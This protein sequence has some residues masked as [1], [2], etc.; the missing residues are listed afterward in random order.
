MGNAISTVRFRGDVEAERRLRED[1]SLRGSLGSACWKSTSRDAR[2]RLLAGAVRVQP[3]L[4]PEAWRA[5][6]RVRE[7]SGDGTRIELY[8]HASPDINAAVTCG[9]DRLLVIL[10]SAAVERLD[11]EELS[12]VLGHE[13]GHGVYGHLGMPTGA[14][15]RGMS[16]RD[17]MR[18]MAWQR[19]AEVSADRAGLL[20]CGSAEAATSA[21]FKSLSGLSLAGRRVD[22]AEFAGQWSELAG[23][24]AMGES[25]GEWAA[26]HPFAPLRARALLHYWESDQAGAMIAECGGARP[27]EEADRAV[28]SMLAMMDPLAEERR[29]LADPV[30]EPFVL[31]GGLAVALAD[32]TLHRT[33]LENLRS[34]VEEGALRSALAERPTVDSCCERFAEARARRARPLSALDL[35]RVFGALSAVA[36]ADGMVAAEETGVIERLASAC[37]V[38]GV[39]V[40][41]VLARAA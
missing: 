12:F 19:A 24:V 31:W 25:T 7:R 9:G 41:R 26:T 21:L 1:E 5:A 37:G 32:G 2:R 38:S 28:S 35:T 15:L 13:L 27:L 20:C 30:L 6:E 29:G 10:T 33:E 3:G 22:G 18:V 11:E 36:G 4:V 16:A 14:A 34:I 23:E 40:E 17:A 8:V 39:F